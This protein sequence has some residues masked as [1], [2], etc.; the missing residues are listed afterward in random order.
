M[1]SDGSM[2]EYSRLCSQ[3]FQAVNQ[4]THLKDLKTYYFHNCVYDY[5]F[6]TPE[7]R[8]GKWVDTD[9]VFGNLDSEYKVI[10]VGDAA[11]MVYGGGSIKRSGLYDRIKAETDKAGLTIIDFPGIDPNPRI[12]S[13]NKGAA[14]CKREHIDV[15]LA[16]GGGSTIDATKF[17]GAGTFYD[18]D[19]CKTLLW[20][21]YPCR[22]GAWK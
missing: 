11:M 1:D 19:A 22:T 3:L 6:T 2:R 14:I 12:T 8:R 20:Q 13:V 21:L 15:L 17:I 16:V 4:S 9:W 5:L 7:C 10:F 18:G